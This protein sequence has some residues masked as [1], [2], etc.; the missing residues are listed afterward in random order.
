MLRS[1]RSLRRPPS[2]PEKRTFQLCL[3]TRIDITAPLGD[4]G[5]DTTAHSCSVVASAATS[6]V[7]HSVATSMHQLG[8]EA[9]LVV[10][11]HL[12]QFQP[13][14]LIDPRRH[15][16]RLRDRPSQTAGP[17]AGCGRPRRAHAAPSCSRPAGGGR[18]RHGSRTAGTRVG[19]TRSGWPSRLAPATPS[20]GSCRRHW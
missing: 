6:T 2:T 20:A 16:L 7:H 3:D 14:H 8:P 9:P 11:G 15:A 1:L 13:L 4:D 10:A 17:A 5:S 18:A 19:R 12:D